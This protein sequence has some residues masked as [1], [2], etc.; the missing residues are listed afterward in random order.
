MCIFLVWPPKKPPV[1]G[2]GDF[3]QFSTY[4]HK[5]KIY[6]LTTKDFLS[7]NKSFVTKKIDLDQ[8]N[9]SF[10]KKIMS[11][12]LRAPPGGLLPRSRSKKAF[13]ET[14]VMKIR[15]FLLLKS[16]FSPMGLQ[17][18]VDIQKMKFHERKNSRA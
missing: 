14:R 16:Y 13:F 9:L 11:N 1:G 3:N 6:N 12:P 7:D 4:F 18:V 15:V 5:F 8:F 17:N 10:L 2:A